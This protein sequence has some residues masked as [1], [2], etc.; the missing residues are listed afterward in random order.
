M[1]I[2][3]P[4]LC[5]SCR[6]TT[7][8]KMTNDQVEWG[9][10]ILLPHHNCNCH[11]NVN[12]LPVNSLN[13]NASKTRLVLK[14]YLLIYIVLWIVTGL[15]S[16]V[17][18]KSTLLTFFCQVHLALHEHLLLPVR[19]WVQ[20][21]IWTLDGAHVCEIGASHSATHFFETPVLH[22]RQDTKHIG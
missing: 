17:N 9:S 3:L 6:K 19:M 15:V 8:E 10:C 18:Y 2:A 21:N 11:S 7:E 1:K 14:M 4:H 16:N 20:F 13:H 12:L 5:Q 22:M